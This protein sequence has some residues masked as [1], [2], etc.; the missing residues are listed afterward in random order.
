[1]SLTPEPRCRTNEGSRRRGEGID[2]REPAHVGSPKPFASRSSPRSR[3]RQLDHFSQ[4]DVSKRIRPKRSERG[5]TSPSQPEAQGFAAPSAL[6]QPAASARGPPSPPQPEAPSAGFLRALPA[7][8][9]KRRVPP[10]PQCPMSGG[11]RSNSSTEA[12]AASV[13]CVAPARPEPLECDGLVDRTSELLEDPSTGCGEH[14]GT[15]ADAAGWEGAE[16]PLL[17]LRAG[18]APRTPC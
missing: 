13:S 14:G 7:R 9:A 18:R 2:P 12:R 17:T 3:Y 16:D 11:C 5:S 15:L 10:R 1:M 8:S 6:S 4:P